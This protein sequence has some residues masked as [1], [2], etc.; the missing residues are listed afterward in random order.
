MYN[1]SDHLHLS[2]GTYTW[3][4]L[5]GNLLSYFAFAG[6][7]YAGLRGA[8]W[9]MCGNSYG[10]GGEVSTEQVIYHVC[11]DQENVVGC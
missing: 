5:K 2:I 8:A 6:N 4:L 3:Y 9:C 1:P 11:W 10:L 7:K